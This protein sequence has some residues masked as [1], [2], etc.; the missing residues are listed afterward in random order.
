MRN[1]SLA[2]AALLLVLAAVAGCSSTTS[3]AGPVFS[4]PKSFT[5]DLT[6]GSVKSVAA[7][8]ADQILS[9]KLTDGST[10][11]VPYLD[12]TTVDRMLADYPGVG[13]SVDGK[14]KR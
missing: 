3:S 8:T 4:G 12:L 13:Y 10:Y 9:V 6:S 7:T 2:L 5:A 14:V 11:T 1:L